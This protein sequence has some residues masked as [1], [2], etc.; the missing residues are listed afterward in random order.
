MKRHHGPLFPVRDMQSCLF[1]MVHL[2]RMTMPGACP[3]NL[4]LSRVYS[5][6]LACP[7]LAGS[8]RPTAYPYPSVC[9]LAAPAAGLERL[10]WEY[11]SICN[12]ICTWHPEYCR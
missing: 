4:K 11:T 5:A 2:A 12:C 3:T 10:P 9:D 7:L 8:T 6:L 1:G